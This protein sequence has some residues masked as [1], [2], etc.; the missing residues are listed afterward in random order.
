M[1]SGWSD[2]RT[3]T[4][5]RTPLPVVPADERDLA[6]PAYLGL[7][8]RPDDQAGDET[9]SLPPVLVPAE[10]SGD[11]PRPPRWPL[12]A[13]EPSTG[14]TD[15]VPPTTPTTSTAD[16]LVPVPAQAP[17]AGGSSGPGRGPLSRPVLPWVAAA[18]AVALA[19]GTGVFLGS[20]PEP[21]VTTSSV[22]LQGVRDDGRQEARSPGT[23]RS[24]GDQ[25]RQAG[26]PRGDGDTRRGGARQDGPREDGRPTGAAQARRDAEPVTSLTNATAP[27]TA[28]PNEDLAGRTVRYAAPNMLDGRDETAWRMVGDG[29]GMVL[30]FTFSS[31]VTLTTV[32]L[33]NGYAKTGSSGGRTVDWYAGN[34]RIRQVEWY[35][36]DGSRVVHSLDDVAQVQR[37]D[38]R[39]RTTSTLRLRL[40]RVSGPGG[41]PDRRDY[42]AISEVALEGVPRPARD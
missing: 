21:V 6:L 35:F 41:G 3:D 11:L 33:L 12:Y 32:G 7:G 17:A 19:A 34:R 18:M 9:R 4:A 22:S 42:T 29:Q 38:I 30:T 5:E 40:T 28:P 25:G 24:E 37:T 27:S 39:P 16:R 26:R 15:P 1:S 2:W 8:A 36:D 13:D 20:R 10:P 14:T 31:P 23:S